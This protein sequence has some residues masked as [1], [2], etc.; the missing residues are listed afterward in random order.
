MVGLFH[1]INAI[2]LAAITIAA[3]VAV[4]AITITTVGTGIGTGITPVGVRV[5]ICR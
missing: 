4:I 1:D 2:L 3:A 5:H